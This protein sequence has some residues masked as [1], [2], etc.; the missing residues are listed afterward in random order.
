MRPRQQ[1]LALLAA[2]AGVAPERAHA[3]GHRG[4]VAARHAALGS[5]E[6]GHAAAPGGHDRHPGAHRLQHREGRELVA[7]RAEDE[8]RGALEQAGHLGA[9]H[10]A[11]HLHRR[12]ALARQRGEL[13]RR[14]DRRRRSAAA[15]RPGRPPRSRCRAP[16]PARAARPRARSG[17][18]A[19][20]S[21]RRARRPAGSA[22]STSSRSAGTPSSASWP[23]AQRLGATKRATDSKHERLVRRQAGGVDGR[24]GKRAAAV[25]D[26]AGQRVA[27]AAAKAR[28]AVTSRDADGAEE[29]RVVQMEDHARAGLAG[30]GEAA[31]PDQRL[32][33]VGVDDVGAELA[34]R[35]AA[36]SGLRP[37]PAAQHRQRR[38]A[39]RPASADRRSSSRC[40]IPAF[41]SARSWSSTERSS[42]PSTR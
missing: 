40:S 38:L 41:A 8:H 20:P 27:T 13:G 18:G 16:S 17:P 14:R 24:L 29:A 28:R 4:G 5:D 9:R 25:E 10:S 1:R 34:R 23:A 39:P 31:R 32:H 15:P 12:A 19:R 35:R 42:P 21:R 11:E 6:L 2:P 7:A 3:A 26:E 22:G 37:P 36:T 30:G 33:V